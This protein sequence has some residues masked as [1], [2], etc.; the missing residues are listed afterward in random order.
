M[1]K[2]KLNEIKRI[3][4]KLIIDDEFC[5]RYF[6]NDILSEDVE[7]IF[8]LES[9]HNEEVK[10]KHPLAG[11]SGVNMTKFFCK[12][13]N[14]TEPRYCNKIAPFGKLVQD[15][16]DTN[17]DDKNF[18]DLYT[19]SKLR[20]KLRKIGIMNVCNIPL[21]MQVYCCDDI[22]KYCEV[23]RI[24]DFLRNRANFTTRMGQNA[25]DKNFTQ[26]VIKNSLCSKVSNY[27]STLFVP[28]GNFALSYLEECNS[29]LNLKIFLVDSKPIPHPSPL[30]KEWNKIETLDLSKSKTLLNHFGSKIKEILEEK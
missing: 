9:P 6:I 23:F 8:L 25:S 10:C 27:K 22:R 20:V 24:L 7:I 16:H 3:C 19:N 13:F 12:V 14:L 26:N 29:T 21:Q 15:A 2:K 11:K 30:S 17:I 4:K 1:R 5:D 18:V 28:M